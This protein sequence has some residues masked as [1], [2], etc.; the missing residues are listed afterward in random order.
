MPVLFLQRKVSDSLVT[1]DLYALKDEILLLWKINTDVDVKKV[2]HD[3]YATIPYFR[4]S[5][6]HYEYEN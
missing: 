6:D 4:A 5:S 2:E 1:S 3:M